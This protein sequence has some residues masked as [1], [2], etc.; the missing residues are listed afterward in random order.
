MCL[1]DYVIVM[2]QI[3]FLLVFPCVVHNSDAG[4]EVHDLF[5]GRVVQVVAALVSPVAVNPLESQ[6]T[7]R[8]CSVSH[9]RTCFAKKRTAGASSFTDATS[10][11]IQSRLS[12]QSAVSSAASSGQRQTNRRH[13]SVQVKCTTLGCLHDVRANALFCFRRCKSVLSL[14]CTTCDMCEA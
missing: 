11:H 9:V 12:A 7:V 5:G 4:D 13:I 3:K 8:S 14:A 1:P 10:R 6:M 2:S